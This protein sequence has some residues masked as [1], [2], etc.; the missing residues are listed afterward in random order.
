MKLL[1]TKIFFVLF[2]GIYSNDDDD[3]DDDDDY[4]YYYYCYSYY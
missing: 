3:D 1:E 4:Y 2:A